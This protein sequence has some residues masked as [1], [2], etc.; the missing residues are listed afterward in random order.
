MTGSD[1]ES[2]LKTDSKPTKSS[3]KM[4]DTLTKIGMPNKE[5]SVKK[6]THEYHLKT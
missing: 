5:A 2:S 6:E 4:E 1:L 3:P